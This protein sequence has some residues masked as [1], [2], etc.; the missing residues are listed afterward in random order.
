MR[1]ASE[2]IAR[3]VISYMDRLSVSLLSFTPDVLQSLLIT[4][5]LLSFASLITASA[6]S[7]M[8]ELKLWNETDGE[9]CCEHML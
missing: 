9:D 7:W 6:H 8:P 5:P 3:R 4:A 1:G 2:A